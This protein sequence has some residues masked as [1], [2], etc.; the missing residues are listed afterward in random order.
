MAS[1][2]ASSCSGASFRAAGSYDKTEEISLPLPTSLLPRVD[3]Q[4]CPSTPIY[5]DTRGRYH[6]ALKQLIRDR[7]HWYREDFL[8]QR[9]FGTFKAN[10]DDLF[11]TLPNGG[12]FV[13]W[14]Q[15]EGID[16]VNTPVLE[17]SAWTNND[18]EVR[19]H[20]GSYTADTYTWSFVDPSKQYQQLITKTSVLKGDHVVLVIGWFSLY[21]HILIDH[22]GYL[23]YLS[24]TLPPTTRFI[25]P[26][27][28]EAA[29]LIYATILR[30]D[31]DLA[32]RLDFIECAN[33][34]ICR[35]HEIQVQDG[36]LSILTPQSPTR[37]AE[38]YEMFRSWI[39]NSQTL[40]KTLNKTAETFQPTVVYY[41]RKQNS[42]AARVFNARYMSEQQEIDIINRIKHAL[43]RYDR[44][45]KLVIFDGSLPFLEQ[46][47]LFESA[48]TIIGPHGGGLANILLTTP[49]S[50]CKKRPKV[51]E[52]VTSQ[53]T[54]RVQRGDLVASYYTLYATSPW[55]E[56]HQVLFESR[57]NE[58]ETFISMDSF[59][60]ALKS[61]F[62]D[63]SH[64]KT[65][66]FE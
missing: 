41:T 45:E 22:L 24:K 37:H 25:V 39:Y 62:G 13:L 10:P 12:S 42:G 64:T 26:R 65:V 3:P 34:R 38:L 14:A 30:I 40:K 32:A 7:Q 56:L 58:H 15:Q 20:E 46:L 44:P 51:L 28:G 2:Y 18:D 4:N 21:Q 27:I 35:N 60:E 59:E 53:E 61:I 17:M 43:Y 16:G 63:G 5:H 29:G 52:F 54:P 6:P 1:I 49:A 19:H 57:S 66:E 36:S 33:Y 9:D 31:P 50:T 8:V 23:V 55:I 48:T 11:V 47:K